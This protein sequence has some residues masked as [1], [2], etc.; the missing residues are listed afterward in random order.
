MTN[1]RAHYLTPEGLRVPAATV[2]EWHEVARIAAQATGPSPA[3]STERA[4]FEAAMAVIEMLAARL[5]DGPLGDGR[6]GDGWRRARVL[7]LCGAGGN[8]AAGVCAARHLADRGVTVEV[9][10]VTPPQ[11]AD[12]ILGQQFLTLAEAPARVIR[13]DEAFTAASADLVVDAVIGTG[14]HGEPQAVQRGLIRAALAAAEAGVAVLS[15]DVPSGL[16]ADTGRAPG[17]V[18]RPARTLTFA[19]PKAGLTRATAGE[20]WVADLGIPPGVFARAG[21][22]FAPFFG[23]AGRVRLRAPGEED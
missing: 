16:D 17:E 9:V 18:V 19:L 22:A 3:Q 12:G 7:L 11:R 14:L 23:A 13:W 8:G 4:G 1:E 21:I 10:T 15:L 2:A 6:P 20:L 5:G